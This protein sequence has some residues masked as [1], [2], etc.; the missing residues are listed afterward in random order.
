MNIVKISI[1][2]P[3]FG[4]ILMSALVI[5]GA[6]SMNKLGIS[7]MPDVNFPVLN[8]S[9]NYPGAAPEVVES[10]II[11]TVEQR[12]L[13]VEG[14]K[15]MKATAQQ[16]QATITLEFDI[17]RNVDVALQEVQSAL[18]Q[19]RFPTGVDPAVIRKTNP[20]EDPILII[21][22]YGDKSIEEMMKWSQ[23]TFLDQI[24][25]LPGVG[26][27]NTG[28][29]PDR[30]LRIW[31]DVNKL[32]QYELTVNDV[33]DAVRTQHLE[34]AAGQY[35][36]GKQEIRVR[37]LGE[38]KTAD[39]IANFPI[40][41]RGGQL[42]QDRIFH[43]KD[44]AEVRDSLADIRRVAR[45]DNQTAVVF[46]IFKQRGTNEVAVADSV[47]KKLGEIKYPEGV[48]YRINVNFTESTKGTVNLGCFDHHDHRMLFVFR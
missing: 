8:V 42:I 48:K 41:R 7:Q 1:N 22:L 6:I 13:T 5:F 19:I 44:V 16:G 14:V 23:N 36:D 43:I 37:Y 28:G 18:S 39:E 4:W 10:E 32:R 3:V 46:R 38:A 24:Q 9:I 11:D 2:R 35:S 45:V 47:I 33:V 25:F 34:S 27:I 12:L 29:F 30:N 40:Q 21:A 17:N 20:E 15:E 26:E 31:L